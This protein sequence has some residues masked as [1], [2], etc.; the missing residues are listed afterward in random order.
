M[1]GRPDS[2]MFKRVC[3][4]SLLE[5]AVLI[6][7]QVTVRE[8]RE[9]NEHTAETKT[10]YS[11]NDSVVRERSPSKGEGPCILVVEDRED[12]TWATSSVSSSFSGSPV[13]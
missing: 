4:L 9:F 13:G 6:M 7:S 8:L 12:R 1:S 5:V 11:R 3:I 2:M 10:L